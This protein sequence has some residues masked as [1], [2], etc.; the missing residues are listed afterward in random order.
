[1]PTC[2]VLPRVALVLLAACGAPPAPIAPAPMPVEAPPMSTPPTAPDAAPAP[3]SA[4][5]TIPTPGSGDVLGRGSALGLDIEVLENVEK[6][7]RAGR[8]ADAAPR[9]ARLDM[10]HAAATVAARNELAHVIVQG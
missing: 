4:T 9:V 3:T 6:L 8:L 7:A 1:M 10:A 5:I 2:P